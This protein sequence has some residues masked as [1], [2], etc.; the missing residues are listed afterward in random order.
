MGVGDHDS[1]AGNSGQHSRYA[2][3]TGGGELDRVGL[4]V[5]DAAVDDVDRVE[6]AERPQPQPALTHDHIGALDQCEPEE[7]GELRILHVTGVVDASAEQHDA[8][9]GN[10]RV[11]NEGATKDA[12]DTGERRHAIL[13]P[14]PLDRQHRRPVE[15][16]VADPSR[17]VGQ[18]AHDPPRPVGELNDVGGVRGEPP[19]RRRQPDGA[20]AVPGRRAQRLARHDAI[21]DEVARSVQVGEDPFHRLDALHDA[22]RQ[23]FER[24][25]IDHERHRI[26]TPRTP[27]DVHLVHKVAGARRSEDSV[28]L[29]LAADQCRSVAR[30]PH[31]ELC[32]T[33][34][35]LRRR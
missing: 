32:G 33:H 4:V 6:P 28:G 7:P 34:V 3:A 9:A 18:I 5:V 25:A 14:R 13:H 27:V 10:R 19:R 12:G 15:Q 26:D 1:T 21:G 23:T 8:R 11:G 2:R 31:E 29:G 35:A 30:Q 22:G 24:V 16:C 17:R 20:D